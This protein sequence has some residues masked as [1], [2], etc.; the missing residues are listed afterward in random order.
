MLLNEYQEK[1]K[2][3]GGPEQLFVFSFLCKNQNQEALRMT[4]MFFLRNNPQVR[5]PVRFSFPVWYISFSVFHF[6]LCLHICLYN[7]TTQKRRRRKSR[8]RIMPSLCSTG[9]LLLNSNQI[10][11]KSA[12]T[13]HSFTGSINIWLVIDMSAPLLLNVSIH[14]YASNPSLN[15]IV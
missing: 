5:Q 4:K 7:R 8:R 12:F 14:I 1:K 2:E 15:I 13:L 10:N 3:I 6:H 11:I 9:K